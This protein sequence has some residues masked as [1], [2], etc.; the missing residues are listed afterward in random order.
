MG[1]IPENWKIDKVPT[2]RQRISTI[3]LSGVLSLFFAI[4]GLAFAWMLITAPHTRESSNFYFLVGVAIFLLVSVAV[5]VRSVKNRPKKLNAFQAKLA[6]YTIFLGSVTMLVM[7]LF[8]G[9]P[10]SRFYMLAISLTGILMG[11]SIIK[12]GRD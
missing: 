8:G 6:G 7:A 3:A 1:D 12:Q 2:R 11:A 10:S 5:F 4:L 9:E